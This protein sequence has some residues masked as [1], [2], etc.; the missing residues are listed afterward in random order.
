[1]CFLFSLCPSAA[2]LVGRS[3][4]FWPGPP[5]QRPTSERSV[6]S[7]FRRFGSDAGQDGFFWVDVAREFRWVWVAVWVA[8]WVGPSRPRS[9][10][11]A[12]LAACPHRRLG[13]SRIWRRISATR[14]VYATARHIRSNVLRTLHIAVAP[15][16]A[17]QKAG[18]AAAAAAAVDDE[19]SG[20]QL[21][22]G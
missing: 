10:S 4:G 21:S 16:G 11:C 15:A 3:L 5:P 14:Y 18:A 1:M 8:V 20:G 7:T 13:C 17:W 2:K 22:V 19:T 6:A 12:W 9:P